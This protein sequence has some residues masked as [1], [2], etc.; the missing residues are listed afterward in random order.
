MGSTLN[1]IVDAWGD[2]TKFI[3]QQFVGIR[4]PVQ[5]G[6]KKER[7]RETAQTNIYASPPKPDL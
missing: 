7:K 1:G 2:T 4:T 5:G 6:E 3:H